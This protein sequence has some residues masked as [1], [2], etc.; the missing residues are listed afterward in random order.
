M[1]RIYI[2]L[3]QSNFG[4]NQ[5]NNFEAVIAQGKK[6][7]HWFRDN[8]R[9][10]FGPWIRGLRI[11]G[12]Q[13]NVAGTGCLIQSDYGTGPHGNFEVI[14]PLHLGNGLP[15]AAKQEFTP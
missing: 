7:W 15:T 1:S 5:H 8:S 14:V 6:L 9:D 4:R 10:N 13:D 2:S 12:D 3:I 11:T